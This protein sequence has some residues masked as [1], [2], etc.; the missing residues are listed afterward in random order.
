MHELQV[1]LGWPSR[2]LHFGGGRF[3]SRG[4]SWNS[5]SAYSSDFVVAPVFVDFFDGQLARVEVKL[6]SFAEVDFEGMVG[7]AQRGNSAAFRDWVD[8]QS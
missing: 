7:D 4:A 6:L 3:A 8:G 5:S 2:Y 1:K